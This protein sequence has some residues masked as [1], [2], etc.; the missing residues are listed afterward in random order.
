MTA[1][2]QG[3]PVIAIVDDDISIRVALDRLTRSLGYPAQVF[4]AAEPL[5]ACLADAA[6][7]LV[8]TDV[9][10]PTLSGLDLLR[11]LSERAPELPVLVMT[12]Y[13]SA[14]THARALALGAVA[15]LAKPFDAEQ[16][17]ACLKHALGKR[18]TSC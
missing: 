18:R 17:E 4:P 14:A 12:A 16:F 9:Q 5:L 8:V 10:M 7:G 1:P 13:P 15:C 3:S 11:I 2:S 6:F